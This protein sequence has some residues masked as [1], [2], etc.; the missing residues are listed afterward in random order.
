MKCF[1][2]WLTALLLQ[3]RHSAATT[4]ALEGGE[5]NAFAYF[6][7]ADEVVRG[8]GEGAGNLSVCR[9]ASGDVE[10]VYVDS[11]L[12]ADGAGGGGYDVVDREH[13]ADLGPSGSG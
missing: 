7:R 3:T 9:C 8:G 6:E 1:T 10:I 13:R 2:R 11:D 5:G 4:V 12:A